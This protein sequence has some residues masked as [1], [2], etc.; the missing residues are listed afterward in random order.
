MAA[1]CISPSHRIFLSWADPIWLDYSPILSNDVM[2]YVSMWF[3]V[4]QCIPATN[5]L[6]KSIKIQ[7][8]SDERRMLLA[9]FRVKRQ[10]H[11][12]HAISIRDILQRL[13]AS[14]VY[15]AHTRASLYEQ[16]EWVAFKDKC[17]C[18]IA[19]RAMLMIIIL[20]SKSNGNH[21]T[22]WND[23]MWQLD[24]FDHFYLSP[25]LLLVATYI[26]HILLW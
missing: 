11:L 14:D 26:S 22:G 8:I 12:T 10:F 2:Y 19:I 7:T 18:I 20:T 16:R 24:L 15:R 13:I 4:A 3:A 5:F 6:S 23:W 1:I 17:W 9:S 21:P 25:P